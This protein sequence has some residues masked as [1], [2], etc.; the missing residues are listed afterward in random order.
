MGDQLSSTALSSGVTSLGGSQ[1]NEQQYVSKIRCPE[2]RT[3]CLSHTFHAQL[4]DTGQPHTASSQQPN[5]GNAQNFDLRPMSNALPVGSEQSPFEA[6]RPSGQHDTAS[7]AGPSSYQYPQQILQYGQQRYDPTTIARTQ[8][9]QQHY[10]PQQMAPQAAQYQ[11]AHRPH[12][13]QMQTQTPFPR[14]DP[15]AFG[16]SPSAYSP[17]DMRFP[18][19]PFPM[20][21]GPP[22]GYQDISRSHL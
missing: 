9:Q 7:M 22:A 8:Q 10:A 6:R 11:Y 15:Y 14:M 2:R 16:V 5:S 3:D 20:G 13:L 21:Y 18:Q 4:D 19:Q 12:S 17:M 1:Q